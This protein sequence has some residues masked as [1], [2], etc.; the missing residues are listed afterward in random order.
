[1]S[2]ISMHHLDLNLLK[3]FAAIWQWRNLTRAADAL[4]LTPSAV[5]HALKRLREVASDPLFI[6]HAH[7]Q[8]APT[9]VCERLAPQLLGAM[10]DIESAFSYL[11]TFTPAQSEQR[12]FIA[13]PEVFELTVL[14]LLFTQLQQHAPRVQLVSCRLE[15]AQM[16]QDLAAGRLHFAFDIA[17]SASHPVEHCMY[18]EDEYVVVLRHEHPLRH[19]LSV[20]DYLELRHIQVSKRPQGAS[21]DELALQ[22]AGI[23]RKAPTWRCQ[24]YLAAMRVLAHTDAALTLPRSL[25]QAL[26]DYQHCILPVPVALE[27]MQTH[28]Y[29]Y[30]PHIKETS[31]AWLLALLMSLRTSIKAQE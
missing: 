28:L 13:M 7:H 8:Y 12:F 23:T 20:S 14:P 2:V 25:A 15:R 18:M 1:M 6:R 24:N 3:V 19:G 16:E 4:N 31:Y 10:K 9:P 22:K 17:K 21:V 27:R 29:W 26:T 5:S 11:D 30:Q